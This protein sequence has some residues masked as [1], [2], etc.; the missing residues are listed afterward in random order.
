MAYTVLGGQ[1]LLAV[2]STGDSH[3]SIYDATD[4][5]VPALLAQGNNTSGTLTANSNGTGQLAWGAIVNNGDG[6]ASQ[7]LYAMSTNQ[8]IQAFVVTVPEPASLTLF[9]TLAVFF[10]VAQ[11]RNRV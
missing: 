7:V 1:A 5:A 2:Q 8:G 11:R 3:V 4:P 6:T 9:A 10:L